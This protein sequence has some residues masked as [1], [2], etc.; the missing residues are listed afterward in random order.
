MKNIK[1]LKVEGSL[2]LD[3]DDLIEWLKDLGNKHKI[4]KGL[5]E[6]MSNDI[7]RIKLDKERN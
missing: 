2:Y 4:Y 5:F 1:C 7:E 6:A 3:I